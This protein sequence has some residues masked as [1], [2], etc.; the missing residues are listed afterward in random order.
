MPQRRGRARDFRPALERLESRCLLAVDAL[1][2]ANLVTHYGSIDSVS[3]VDKVTL[4]LQTGDILEVQPLGKP[5]DGIRYAPAVE[6]FLPDGSPFAA[7]FDGH[8][9]EVTIPFAGDYTGRISSEFAQRPFLGEYAVAFRI[10]GWAGSHESEA[11][12]SFATAD[13]LTLPAGVRGTLDS[14]SDRDFY[15]FDALAGQTLAVKLAN[16]PRHNPAVRLFDSSH[17]LIASA[18]D[19]NGLVATLGTSGTYYLSVEAD[20]AAGQVT[21]DYVASVTVLERATLESLSGGSFDRASVI[22]WDDAAPGVAP[23]LPQTVCA[24]GILSDMD[25]VDVFAVELVAG[26]AYEFRLTDSAQTLATQERIVAVSNE[27]GQ[28]LEYTVKGSLRTGVGQTRGGRHLLSVSP[29]G[30]AGLG[31]YAIAISAIGSFPAQR[32]VPLY[33]FDF[34]GSD[35]QL[36]AFQRPEIGPAIMGMFEAVYGVNDIDLATTAPPAGVERVQ[37]SIGFGGQSTPSVWYGSG[38]GQRGN[39]RPSGDAF[40]D[41]TGESG[42]T[43]QY[44]GIAAFVCARR[45]AGHATGLQKARRAMDVMSNDRQVPILPPGDVFRFGE[46]PLPARGVFHER[47]YLDWTTQA[48]RVVAESEPNNSIPTAQQLDDYFH[49]MSGDSDDRNDKVIVVGLIRDA[50]DL[51]FYQFSAAAGQSFAFDIDAAEFQ[52]PVDVELAIFDEA[53]NR[54]AQSSDAIDRETG[55]RSADPYLTF[56]FDAS[57]T[58]FIEVRS[59]K[60]TWGN[61]R[62]KVAPDRSWD[63]QGP[64]VLASWPDGGRTVDSTRQLTFWF[65]KQLD[66]AT[67]TAANIQVRHSSGRLQTGSAWFDPTDATLVWWA[68]APLDTGTYSVT[69]GSGLTGIRDLYGNPL[70]GETDGT[71]SWPEISGDGKPGGDFETSFTVHDIDSTPAIVTASYRSH[72][73]NYGL[74]T[75]SFTDELDYGHFLSN[76]SFLLRQAGADEA[77]GTV[78]DVTIPLRSA[79]NKL[80]T[81]LGGSQGFLYTLGVP[82]PALYR[83]EGSVRDAAG[84]E[85][86]LSETLNVAGDTLVTNVTRLNIQPGTVLETGPDRIEVAFSGPVDVS[87]LTTDNMRLR[88]SID[89]VFFDGNDTYV[90]DADGLITWDPTRHVATLQP[91][92]PLARGYYLLELSGRPGG[93][94]DKLG[95]L[96]DGE[97]LDATIQ[98]NLDSMIWQQSPSGDGLPGGDYR[99]FFSVQDGGPAWQNPRGPMDVNDDT[100]VTAMD[101]LLIVNELNNPANHDPSGRLDASPSGAAWPPYYDV[102]GDDFVTPLDVM[103]I[104]NRLNAQAFGEAEAPGN[105]VFGR[106]AFA[107]VKPTSS[108][109]S[110]TATALMHPVASADQDA[111]ECGDVRAANIVLAHSLY[112]RE[113]NVTDGTT[114]SAHRSLTE[115]ELELILPCLAAEVA[116]VMEEGALS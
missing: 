77:F 19:G 23:A 35:G 60:K 34:N 75:L 8:S 30:P 48:G 39:R 102:S 65:N 97:Y 45:G 116:R 43:Q 100:F 109:I 46:N 56:T 36:A 81:T 107:F 99:A 90:P 40:C 95:R 74:V 91:A 7:S 110:G 72:A 4:S 16:L 51:D 80:N 58:Y 61:Y 44:H 101:V 106:T 37:V 59:A 18:L 5:E 32:D 38:A 52:N 42:W 89:P 2:A 111:R 71:L 87:T 104:I 1:A 103:L 86:T 64:R 67:L 26:A 11:N 88:R 79:V 28:L 27:F 14:P 20:N 76:T 96:L 55:L 114:G 108:Q 31:A 63:S 3:D 83:L 49:E 98:N 25:D 70:D 115:D 15:R 78:D 94:A 68:D 47:D 93:I 12:D 69:L 21:G 24:A 113:S 17:G 57:G 29:S 6:W 92:S 53:G 73:Y 9:Y 13:G 33:Y 10:S 66:P 22:S 112:L 54:L 82:E 105:Q 84:H 41:L 85:I 50:S 62:L